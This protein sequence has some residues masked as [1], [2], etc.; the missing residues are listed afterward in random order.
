LVVSI[1]VNVVGTKSIDGNEENG[2][3]GYVVRFW[4]TGKAGTSS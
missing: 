3:T 4:L 1:A 2:G